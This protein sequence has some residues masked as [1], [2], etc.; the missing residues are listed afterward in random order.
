MRQEIHV[1]IFGAKPGLDGVSAKAD[2]FLAQRQLFAAGDA[3]LQLDEVEAGDGFG[4]GVLDLQ[5][6]VHLHE[7][8][9]AGGV[10]QELHRPDPFVTDRPDRAD[11]GRAHRRAQRRRNRRRRRLLDQLL[12]P[13]LHRAVALAEVDGIAMAVADDLD[14]DV[15]RALDRPLD[16]QSRVAEGVLR[17]RARRAQ[18]GNELVLPRARRMPRPP[19]PAL[20]LIITGKPIRSASAASRS[21]LWS[22]PW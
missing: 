15:T 2:I 16:E 14:F 12:V 5:A 22:S 8:E 3:E 11:G 21:S 4:D 20:A 17:L 1:G 19:P 7:E 13:P 10:E 18:Q 6:R 9:V